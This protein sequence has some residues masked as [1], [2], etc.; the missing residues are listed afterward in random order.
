[1]DI[2]HLQGCPLASVFWVLQALSV[3]YPEECTCHHKVTTIV[4]MSQGSNGGMLLL[5]TEVNIMS[6]DFDSK[7]AR[8]NVQTT[9]SN[10]N[11]NIQHNEDSKKKN[12]FTVNVNF[13]GNNFKG[14][15]TDGDQ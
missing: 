1:M 6:T 11:E 4:I 13:M 10:A 15:L 7:F 8:C 5:L 2:A 3:V 12:K 9:L 14:N